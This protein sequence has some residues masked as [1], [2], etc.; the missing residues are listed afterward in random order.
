[1]F[2]CVKEINSNH[3]KSMNITKLNKNLAGIIHYEHNRT[4][5]LT[6]SYDYEIDLDRIKDE[7]DILWWVC[8]L[9]EKVW[10]DKDRIRAFIVAACAAKGFKKPYGASSHPYNRPSPSIGMP[11]Q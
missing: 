1:M 7:Q 10:M 9:S 3:E 6:W 8:H 5:V 4:L 11:Q 2:G